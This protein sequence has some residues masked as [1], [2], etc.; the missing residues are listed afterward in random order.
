MS[1]SVTI[2][3]R[4]LDPHD[5]ALL[6]AW[7]E[8]GRD[9]TA[10]RPVD[11]WPVWEI[12]RT[13]LPMTRTDSRLVLVSAHEAE[14]M[15]GA[16]MVLLFDQGNRHLGEVDVYVAPPERRR[17]IGR[18]LLSELERICVAEG[19][20]TLV[21]SAFAP[22]DSES[23]G[24]LFAAAT[25]YPVASH[26]ETKTLDLLQAPDGWGPLDDEVAAAL[27]DYR[28]E[29]FEDRVPERWLPDFCVL[30]SALLGEIPTGDLDLEK[31]TWTPERVREH[32]DRAERIGR[33]QVIAV[34]V[35]PD[36]HL[37]GFSDLRINRHDPRHASVGTTLVQPGHR[38]HRLGLALK[39]ASHRRLRELFPECAYIETGNAGVNA[40]MNRVNQ[41]MGYRVAE[42]CLDVQKRLG[43]V[44]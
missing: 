35:A 20:T 44:R 11:A 4:V 32:E 2:E 3:I 25:G 36:G 13:A 40:P 16:G 9:A 1:P 15:V 10:E 18:A 17:G 31:E 7:W 27:G 34:A 30:L 43:E 33:V 38:G 6:R 29:V 5:E 23:P 28:V 41:A 24:S 12:S 19:R 22:K 8:I 14:R 21:S 37:C 39:L 42:R 26:E